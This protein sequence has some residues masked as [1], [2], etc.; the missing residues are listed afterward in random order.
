MIKM[1]RSRILVFTGK[2]LIGA[3]ITIFLV[4]SILFVLLHSIPGGDMVTR[5]HPFASAEVKAQLRQQWG[6]DKPLL[7][8]YLIY[9]KKVFTLDYRLV[10]T[11]QIDA[12][13]ILLFFLPFT[14]LL[15]GTATVLSYIIGVFLGMRLLSEK[16]RW[17]KL[18]SGTSIILYSVPA[19]ILAVYFRTWFVFK[20]SIFPPVA[21]R[22]AGFSSLY[23][24]ESLLSVGRVDL[25]MALL[26][27]M[28]L[29]V[30]ILVMVGLARPLFLLRDQ[31]TIVA[32]EPFVTTARAKG[33]SE[34]AVLSRHVAR[35]ALLPLLNDASIN[36]A[37]IISGGI[38]IEYV[39]S[40][41]GIG[42]V[43]LLGLKT[44]NYPTISAG[45]FLLTVIMLISMIIV[46]VVNAYLDPR[47][48]L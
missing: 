48:V 18:I 41:P 44:L 40:W 11:Q 28:V 6:L 36:L 38:L 31:M 8:Q 32:E 22:V 33:L 17:R 27:G 3:V 14:L 15:F 20:Y 37:L 7:E 24:D 26:P 2:K 4:M 5:M 45:I 10:E 35:C 30:L 43:L 19:F 47:V 29:P 39:F 42:T 13:D 46:D 23:V 34:N 12:M 21:V 16:G 1:S 9:I 25:M